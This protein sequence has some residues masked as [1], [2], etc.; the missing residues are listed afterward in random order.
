MI[1][2]F[3]MNVVGFLQVMVASTYLMMYMGC[4]VIVAAE[5]SAIVSAIVL[6]K[7]QVVYKKRGL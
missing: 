3:I 5:L 1:V 2:Q 4:P 7:F 6:A